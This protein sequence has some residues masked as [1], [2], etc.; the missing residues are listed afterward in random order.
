MFKLFLPIYKILKTAFWSDLTVEYLCVSFYF[1]NTLY[2]VH[3]TLYI[4]TLYIVHCILYICT[5]YIVHCILYIC[6]LYIVHCTLYIVYLYIVHCTLYIVY[7]YIVHCTLYICTLYIVHCTLYISLPGDPPTCC[8][9]QDNTLVRLIQ[10]WLIVDLLCLTPLSAIFQL[11]QSRARTHA[12][13][14]IGL[15]ELLGHPTT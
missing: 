11:Y 8:H 6:T 7:L 5:L 9:G 12:V 4:C 13:L 1:L 2:I 14:V 3:C 10:H 15:Y